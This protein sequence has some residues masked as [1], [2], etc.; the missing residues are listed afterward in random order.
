MLEALFTIGIFLV[1]SWLYGVRYHRVQ[2]GRIDAALAAADSARD[3]LDSAKVL[4]TQAH[5]QVKAV[6]KRVID[7]GQKLD[8]SLVALQKAALA[9]PADGVTVEVQAL[10]EEVDSV[11]VAAQ[12][13]RSQVDSLVLFHDKERRAFDRA[14]AQADSTVAA[15]DTVIQRMRAAECRIGKLPCPTRTQSFL[16]GAILVVWLTR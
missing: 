9:V 2:Q 12:L 13:Y 7:R 10:L 3:R 15:Y 8:T 16:A 1:A 4:V 6:T 11:R 5:Y 14:M